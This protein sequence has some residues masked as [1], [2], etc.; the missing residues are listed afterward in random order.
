MLRDHDRIKPFA[1]LD[2]VKAMKPESVEYALGGASNEA[3]VAAVVDG[4]NYLTHYDPH[5]R[6]MRLDN[7]SLTVWTSR[8]KTLLVIMILRH[9]GFDEH[10]IVRQL[11]DSIS[12]SPIRG[13][14]LFRELEPEG[15]EAAE[16]GGGES[17]AIASNSHGPRAL[18]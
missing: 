7:P 9:L 17:R 15:A 5:G 10:F 13:A 8:M 2:A 1:A 3:F 6:A 16:G 18:S 11:K 4:R 14:R 12:W